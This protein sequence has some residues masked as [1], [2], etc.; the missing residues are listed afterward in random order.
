M[1]KPRDYQLAAANHLWEQ[2]HARPEENP[3]VV[4]PTGTGKSLTMALFIMGLVKQYPFIRV[5]NLTHVKELVAG[6]YGAL[7]ELWPAAPT[8]IYCAGLNRKDRNGQV[9][10]AS[11]DSF[12]G[13]AAGFAKVDFVI[14][15]EAHRISDKERSS[16]QKV[17]TTLREKNPH[18]VVV[19]FTA[20]DYRMGMGKLTEGNFF[21]SVCFDLSS[22]TDF[23]WMLDQRYL[24]RLI[25][26]NPGFQVDDTQIKIRAGEYDEKSASAAFREQDILERAAD[27]IVTQ[28]EAQGRKAWLTFCQSI[29]DSELVADMLRYR[30]YPVEAVHSQ[31]GDRDDVLAKFERGELIGVTN[32]DILTTGYDNPRVDLIAMLRVCRS[33]GLWVQMLGRGTRPLWTAGYDLSTWEGR[34]NSIL[35]SDK[36]NCLVLD[37][38]GNTPRLGP[39]NY[40]KV[41][42]RK[43]AKQG[44]PP[45]RECPECGTYNHISL[46]HCEEC[47]YE[48][49]AAPKF[50]GQ[51]GT[52]ELVVDLNS[53]P[54]P[55]PKEY[56]VFSVDRM[57][58]GVQKAKPNKWPTL[59]V[60]YFCGPRRFS[61]WVCPEHKGFAHHKAKEWW[62]WHA[63]GDAMP[64][65][66]EAMA[67]VFGDLTPPY[68][69]KV[70]LNTKYPEIEDYDFK[71]TGFELPPEL[72]GPE[73]TALERLREEQ[74]ARKALEDANYGYYDGDIPF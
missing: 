3:L 59:R 44:Q 55:P 14:V 1:K 74:A 51:A 10:F 72:G 24:L 23:V 20:T 38:A 5:L 39:I 15:D 47:G 9:T 11:I 6:N 29:D 40:P 70:W 31:R 27:E 52:S 33:P 65:T 56:G 42:K 21:D 63:D 18:L 62:R 66:A 60:D 49:P 35:A 48:F 71:G 57:V 67:E 41:P 73:V 68:F 7:L 30:G 13:A 50:E 17:F 36:Q 25:P 58:C 37:F 61:T 28:A 53:L 45:V 8:G 34:N 64:E 32:K 26:K 22:G 4:M 19:G 46:K 54:P 43:G 69:I 12:R 16:Y 2:V